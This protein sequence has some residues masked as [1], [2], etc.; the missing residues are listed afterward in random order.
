MALLRPEEIRGLVDHSSPLFG[1]RIGTK[2]YRHP[3]SGEEYDYSFFYGKYKWGTLV[4]P[5]TIQNEIVVVR[6][7]RHGINDFVY[8]FPGGNPDNSAEEPIAVVA[9][10]LTQETGYTSSNIV[11]LGE[12]LFIDAANYLGRIFPFIA[13]G[14]ELT[15]QQMLDP[16]EFIEVHRIPAAE[17]SNFIRAGKITDAKT[18]AMTLLWSVQ[19]SKT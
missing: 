10:E 18:L 19:T 17:W 5:L 3:G 13:Y 16:V 6:Q 7:F 9:R 4:I 2:R 14:C 12:A 15:A 1:K 8:E 11:P